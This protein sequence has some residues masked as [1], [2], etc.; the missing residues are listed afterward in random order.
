MQYKNSLFRRK[1]ESE[2]GVR[3]ELKFVW[4]PCAVRKRE[5]YGLT[6]FYQ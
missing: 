2:K 5:N 3:V 1:P 4:Y 6:Y